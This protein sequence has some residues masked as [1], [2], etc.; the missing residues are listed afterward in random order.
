M[1]PAL[2]DIVREELEKL[3]DAG[4]IYPISNS[5]WVS[6]LV[7]VPKKNC[8]W[9]ICV[10]YGELNKATK[11]DHFPLPFIDQA[12]DSLAGKKFFSFLDGFSGYNQIQISPKYQDN[13]IF[14]CRWG[15]FAYWVLPFGFCNAPTTFQRA[16]LRIFSELVHDAVEIYMD[17]FTPY[18]SD[19]QEALSNLGK[20]L[21]KCIE[22]ILSLN[23]EKCEFLMTEGTML[24]QAISQQEL[25]VDPNKIAIIQR[26]P[27]PQKVRDVRS[28]LG[29]AG[30]YKRF[31]KDFNKLASPLFGLL[32]KVVE[33]IWLENCQESLDTLKSKLVRAPI[34]R[35][36]NWALPFH[37]HTNAS[38]KV[39]GADLGQIDEKLPYAIYF[40]SKNLS[41]V[42]LNYTVAEKEFL[43]VM[44]SLNKFRHYIIGYQ[45]FVHTGHAAIR[46]LMNKPNVNAH[47][48][49]WLLLL[50][51][52]DL[53]ILDKHGKENVVADF[54]S[55]VNLP[56]ANY[57]VSTQFPPHLSSKEKS[58][59]V[60]KSA[61]FTWMGGNLFKLGPDQILRRCVREEEVFDIL[62]TCHDGPCGGHFAA[63]RTTFKILQAGY[64]W[65]TLHQDV[66]RYMSQYDRCQRM[67]KPTPKD[68]IPMQ[69]QVTFEPSEKW[70]MDF[71]G[72]I[73]PPLN[74]KQY[75]IVCTD[76]LTKWAETKAI[77]A[78]T[79]EKVAE[80][81]RENIF[82][83]TSNLYHPQAN[84]Q[85]E[86]TNRALEGIL[87]KVVS[88]S[89]KDW[90]NRLV[91]ATW[92][93]NTTWKT[94]TGFTP[95]E[96]VYEKKA[97]LSIEFE[98]NTL[99][100]AAQ[101]DLNLSHAQKE[102]LL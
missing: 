88:S 100:M 38:N 99:R 5:E 68:E 16:V 9:R 53:T 29:L 93:Y 42:E 86:V 34:L 15:T 35:G 56:A 12:L 80:F 94:T 39:I 31:I 74:Q 55:R 98:F 82:Y 61:P 6:P 48:I 96:L 23:L 71:V 101:L 51:Q 66:R 45:T 81:L 18:G 40:I 46:Y 3:L 64:C 50:Q 72:P 28:F 1:N 36:P 58:K 89:R 4:F 69:P 17:D 76:Y 59:I 20:V 70:G 14:T 2:K 62:L 85:V 78:A 54:L 30:Y 102:R 49:R 27:P 87:T 13:T 44:H 21:D 67:G 33:F 26:V 8:K 7:L 75:I 25:Q 22:M 19:F 11:K 63:K 73:N 41:K 43:A 83:N 37:I 77:K 91:E 79:E 24:G 65:S 47:I 90:A 57:V 92:A 52:F 60:R 97:F 84:G 10:D 32:G 95:Y